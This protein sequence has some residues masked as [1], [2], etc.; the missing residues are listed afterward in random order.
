[1]SAL[2]AINFY[3]KF[4]VGNPAIKLSNNEIEQ[5]IR[6]NQ[7]VNISHIGM[8]SFENVTLLMINHGTNQKRFIVQQF[9]E[10]PEEFIVSSRDIISAIRQFI[11]IYEKQVSVLLSPKK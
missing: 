11:I 4:V 8:S 10:N 2:E 1:M 9:E 7:L 5:G 3:N 6:F